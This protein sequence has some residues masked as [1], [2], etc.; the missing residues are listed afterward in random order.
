MNLEEMQQLVSNAVE[1]GYRGRLLAR[2]QA[3]AMIWHD[4]VLPDGAPDFLPLLSYDL[5]SY[6]HSLLL[7]G[8]RL[9][10]EGGDENLMRSAFEHAGESIEAVVSK[11]DP[12]DPRRGFFRLL[13]AASFHLA[14]LS[15]RAFSLLH[16]VTGDINLSRMERAL[17]L[18]I[19]RALDDLEGEILTWSLEGM[20]SD[21]AII[22]D[23]AEAEI[24]S[25]AEEGADLYSDALDRALCNSF[26]GGL[27]AYILAL[28]TGAP[29]LVEDAR[30]ELSKGLESAATL[31]MVPQWWCFR[32]AI[33][34]LDDLW[35]S[36]FHE[37]LPPNVP[38]E[39]SASWKELRSLFITSLFRRK[40]SEIELWPSQIEGAHRSVDVSDNLVVS[41][42]TSA[43]KTR[44]AEL[45]I[46]RCLS[47][48]KRIVFV[49]PLRALSA[50]TEASLRRTF[51]PLGKTISTLYG[52]IG[53]SGFE[54]D[55]LKTRHIV[56]ATPEKL[57]FALRNDPSILDDVG[58]VV[59][60]EGHMIGLGEREVRYELQLQRLLK[61][62][63]ADQRRIVCLSAILP[64]GDQFDDF[65]NWLRRDKEGDAVSVDWRPTR[66]RFGEVLWRTDHARLELRVGD[67]KPFVPNFF[68]QREPTSGQRTALFPRDQRELVLATAWRLVEDRQSV[69]IYCPTRRSVEPFASAIVDLSKRGF[70]QSIL[71]ADPQVLASA[72]SIGAEWLGKN[73]PILKCLSLGIAVHHGALPT[74]FRKEMERL[75]RDGVLKVTVSS[76][77]L[78]QG[79]NL[80]ATAVVIHSLHRNGDLIPASEFKN[81]IGR[82]GRAFIDVE[83]LVLFPIFN[84]HDYRRGQWESLISQASQHSLESGLIR[85]L[86][87]LIF[88]LSKAHGLTDTNDLLEYIVNNAVAW[89]FPEVAGESDDDRDAEAR[90]WEQY[91]TVLDTAL[92]SLLGDQDLDAA[93]ISARLDDLLQSSLWQRRLL[94]RH[95][96]IQN[97][98]TGALKARAN[99][100]WDQSTAP[101]RRG[102]F[103]AGVGLQTGQR[104]DA[105]SGN[106]NNLLIAAN[107]A[108][109][110]GDEEDAVTAII[111]L[112]EIIF[113]IPPFDPDPFPDNWRGVLRAWLE[114]KPLA[115]LATENTSDVLR[116]VENG[117]IY[118]LPWGIEAIRVRAQA[119][120]DTFGDEGMFTID[121][122]EVGLAVPTIETGTLNLS[123]ATLMQA[124]FTS[125]LAAIKAANDTAATFLNSHDLKVWLDSELVQGLSAN[126]DWPTSESRNL[127]LEFTREYVPP[128]RSVWKQ[129]D[130]VIP[131]KWAETLQ[132]LPE[133]STVRLVKNG[134]RTL[135]FSAAMNVIG[136]T[137]GNMV[138]TPRGVLV[139]K[140]TADPESIAIRYFGP[141]SVADL[142]A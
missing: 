132:A 24:D 126:E 46:L 23:L 88:R 97:L 95:E 25:E 82:A 105:V 40:R 21:D 78:A 119:N 136:E 9:R 134:G 52:S 114:G 79:L 13:A 31:N 99:I 56:V 106:A 138:R 44:I 67:E 61:R 59:L 8:I 85:L 64:E 104:L 93:E 103:L 16:E 50:Q 125:R 57:D 116:F 69:L 54:E 139:A 4:G 109:Q 66:I 89:D 34:L 83:G 111:G 137:H 12:D 68:G 26:Y 45:C 72:L 127:W 36:S 58:L 117:L 101:Q 124:G 3:R 129:K 115:E 37:V 133:G 65:V 96:D 135:I 29:E 11:G 38:S 112:A 5:L 55:A 10:E 47:Q 41:L 81:V 91:I 71:K 51:G 118:K 39:D 140:T 28:E 48:G 123:A 131:V 60:D 73:H 92:L 42:P 30:G 15:A 77:T 141:E 84:N 27:G 80:T 17:A 7:L 32:I 53:T 76:P 2:G 90:S 43:G 14:R 98:L 113:D 100:I 120:G 102:Y 86:V 74:P 35:E 87:T 33:H 70:L 6:G 62:P 108:I 18:L 130:T 122:L 1:P 22:V 121:D 94:R 110:E 128:E 63:D 19:L 107:A 20:G 49:T 142:F 75:L